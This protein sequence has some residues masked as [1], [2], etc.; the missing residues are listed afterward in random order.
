[1]TAMR[2]LRTVAFGLMILISGSVFAAVIQ[3]TV[4]DTSGEPLPGVTVEV[5]GLAQ[6]ALVA[7][8]DRSGHYQLQVSPGSYHVNFRLIHFASARRAVSA[9]DQ[10][11]AIADATL[12]LETSASIVVTGKRTFRNLADLD[13]PINGML[14]LADA[15]SVGV[16]TAKQIE[17]RADQRPGDVLET[18]PGVVISQHSGEGKANQYYLRGFNLDHGTDFATTVAGAP[19]NMPTHAHG[20]G[21]SDNNFLI[22]ELI[23]GIQYKK[24]PYYADEG[25]FSSAGAANVNYVNVLDRPLAS[26]TGGTFGYKRAFAAGST[27]LAGGELLGGLEISRNNGPWTHPDEYRKFNGLLRFTGGGHNEA[28]SLTAAAYDGHWNSTDQIPDRAVARGLISRFGN[29]D[30]SDGGS[31]HRDSLVGDW[32]R[33]GENAL[34]RANAYVIGYGLRLFSNFTYF[35]EDP[36]NGDQFEQ[37][38]RRIVAG[39]RASHQWFSNLFGRSSEN[40]IGIDVRHDHIGNIALSHTRNRAVIDTIRSD[41]VLQTSA[42]AFGQSTTQWSDKVRSVLGLR[43]DGDHFDVH[44]GD[45]ANGGTANAA[46]L[47][48]KASLIFGPWGNTEFYVSAGDGFHSNDGRGSTLT[49]DPRTGERADRVSPLVRTT[50][51]EVGLRTLFIPHLQSTLALWGLDMASELVFSGDAGTTEASRPS[52]RTGFEWSNDYHLSSHLV[53]DADLAYSKARFRDRNP[54]G[55]RIPGALEGVVSSG[56]SLYDLGRFSGS[57]RYRYLGPRPLIEDNSVRS[58]PSHVITATA[59]YAITSRYRLVIEGLNLLD[60]RVSDIDY[61]YASRLPDE[62]LAGVSDVHTHP[63]EPRSIRIRFEAT[64]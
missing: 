36:V 21:Y 58:N 48:P 3:G 12:P 62:P 55:A 18:I 6:P 53:F 23:S 40:L 16:I 19:V 41:R 2:G 33:G 57:L 47:S 24:G 46:L 28:Y 1:M 39:G 43:F 27:P 31:S 11:A 59:G 8:T 50:G 5:S 51:S 38:D 60:A 32:Q 45:P 56:L 35:L 37:T 4:R 54:V 42:G 61:Y 44:A 13:T 52:R 30:S 17:N 29:I 25:D 7:V 63:I 22:P 26:V 10:V 34:T 14:G 20:Q 9:D 64:F 49:R 15:A